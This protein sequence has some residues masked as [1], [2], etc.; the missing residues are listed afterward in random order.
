VIAY[1]HEAVFPLLLCYKLSLRIPWDFLFQP[2]APRILALT[3]P[4]SPYFL[5]IEG[6]ATSRSSQCSIT[7]LACSAENSITYSLAIRK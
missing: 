7:A 1:L 2:W 3:M 6:R 5:S 4:S